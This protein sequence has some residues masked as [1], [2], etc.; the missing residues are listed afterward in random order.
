MTY[1]SSSVVHSR[2]WAFCCDVEVVVLV[3]L[4]R[5]FS[6]PEI[7]G[8]VGARAGK[9]IFLGFV[10]SFRGFLVDD[11][12][13]CVFVDLIACKGIVV[14]GQGIVI[15]IFRSNSLMRLNGLMRHPFLFHLFS[16][17]MCAHIVSARTWYLI[18]LVLASVCKV[19]LLTDRFQLFFLLGPIKADVVV[20]R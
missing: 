12:M 20:I 13:T 14:H 7:D 2:R 17:N 11:L 16:S 15:S 18:A 4:R 3:L 1:V 19:S 6:G 9:L 10:L 5:R 8:R